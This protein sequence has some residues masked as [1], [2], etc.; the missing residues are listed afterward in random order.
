[1]ARANRNEPKSKKPLKGRSAVADK[2]ELPYPTHRTSQ[3]ELRTQTN[4]PTSSGV[5]HRGDR[6]DTHPTYTGNQK[7]RAR[8]NTP[9]ANVATRKN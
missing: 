3:N 5:L 4:R 7:H 9:R 1:M 6:R 8:G 2:Q